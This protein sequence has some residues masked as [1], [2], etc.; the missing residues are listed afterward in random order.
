MKNCAEQPSISLIVATMKAY[1]T[2][3]IRERAR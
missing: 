3:E 2:I 1:V